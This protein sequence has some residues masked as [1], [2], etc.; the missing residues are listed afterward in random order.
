MSEITRKIIGVI[1]IN[2]T[3]A[4]SIINIILDEDPMPKSFLIGICVFVWI[5]AMVLAIKY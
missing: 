1:L 2:V 5:L 4:I 3:I